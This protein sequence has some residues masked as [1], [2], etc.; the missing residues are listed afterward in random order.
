MYDGIKCPAERM[1]Y[2]A[3]LHIRSSCKNIATPSRAVINLKQQYK[4]SRGSLVVARTFQLTLSAYSKVLGGL[5][6][7]KM[8]RFWYV[9]GLNPSVF[10]MRI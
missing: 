3:S 8:E 6:V 4:S 5:V 1:S 9:E 2:L 10:G 7:P